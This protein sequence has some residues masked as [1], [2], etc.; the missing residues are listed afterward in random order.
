MVDR[1]C[2]E[3]VDFSYLVIIIK[4]TAEIEEARRAEVGWHLLACVSH[5]L[6]LGTIDHAEIGRDLK[7]A[8]GLALSMQRQTGRLGGLVLGLFCRFLL[9]IEGHK[10]R[11]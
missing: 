1:P 6:N 5:M 8:L 10:H 11:L 4:D 2:T 7:G 9:R 3:A